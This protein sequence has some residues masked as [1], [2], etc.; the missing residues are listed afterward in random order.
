MFDDLFLGPVPADEDCEQ[1]GE[2]Y[3]HARA[4]KEGKAY[5]S[6]LIRLHGEPPEGAMLK[7]KS[8]PHDFGTYCEVVVRYDDSVQAAVEYA[9]RVEGNTPSHWDD[10][11]KAEL[12]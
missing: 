6:Q 4:R 3:N 2:G 1:L 5:I 7:I 10:V 8:C 11:A 9:F 12:K